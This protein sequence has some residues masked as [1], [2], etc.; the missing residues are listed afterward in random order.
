MG[1]EACLHLHSSF[2]GVLCSNMV[3]LMGKIQNSYPAKAFRAGIQ[4]LSV[5]FKG[6]LILFMYYCI[7]TLLGMQ[8]VGSLDLQNL[9]TIYLIKTISN[10]TDKAALH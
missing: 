5:Y 7:S 8:L 3:R 1:R 2:S 4:F 9:N 10:F 6:D